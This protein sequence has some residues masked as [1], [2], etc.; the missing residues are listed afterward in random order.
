MDA[1]TDQLFFIDT[2]KGDDKKDIGYNIIT[3]SENSQSSPSPTHRKHLKRENSENKRPQTVLGYDEEEAELEQLV[4]GG[5]PDI[6]FEEDDN[7]KKSD[8]ERGGTP[9]DEH[10]LDFQIQ[11]VHQFVGELEFSTLHDV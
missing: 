9:T 7:E 5:K 4:F 2:G 10:T 6:L 1:N 8:D 3:A 11:K